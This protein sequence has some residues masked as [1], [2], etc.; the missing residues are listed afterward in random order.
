MLTATLPEVKE[1]LD[2]QPAS[3]IY[4][5][6]GASYKHSGGTVNY[7]RN[8]VR[9]GKNYY[10]TKRTEIPTGYRMSS[11]AEELAIQLALEREG[12][13]PR[14]AEVFNDLFAGGNG[15]WYAW[16][17]TGTGLRVP[18]GREA[19][20]YETDSQG[21]EYYRR[22]V[23]I[24]DQEVGE[25]LVPEGEGRVVVEWDEV[26]GM[27]RVTSSSEGDMR[28]NNYTTHFWFKPTPEKDSIS[29]HYDVAVGRRG[30]WLHDE[31]ERCLD[32]D[33]HYGRSDAGSSDGFRPVQGSFPEIKKESADASITNRQHRSYMPH[34]PPC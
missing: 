3:S 9:T 14:K 6:L 26:F 32:V 25:I 1:R 10:D 21:R 33:A 20:R 23:L 30:N 18:K 2:I 29:G 16:Q 22:I 17:W 7:S 19:S 12:M 27:P 31:D 13:D 11:A 28:Y 5:T 4:P 15:G 24:E 34:G 8:L